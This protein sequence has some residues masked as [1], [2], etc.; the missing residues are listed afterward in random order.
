MAK[1]K[2]TVYATEYQTNLLEKAFDINLIV[3]G[4]LPDEIEDKILKHIKKT[5]YES[6]LSEVDVLWKA[7]CLKELLDP[8]GGVDM[9]F[10]D[11]Y[12]N[13]KPLKRAYPKVTWL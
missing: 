6:R 9:E 11:R 3:K 2:I 5:H 4:A 10:R 1:H 12:A 8:F 7:R 13:S